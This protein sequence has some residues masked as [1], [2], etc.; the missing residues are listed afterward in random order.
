MIIDDNN[1]LLKVQVKFTS[2]K[3]KNNVFQVNLKS[4]GGTKGTVY[5]RV[6]E[7][8]IDILLAVTSEKDIYEIP[9]KD[10]ENKASLN[11]GKKYDKYKVFI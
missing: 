4:C 3:S 1:N 11:L 9:C 8:D 10:I 6:I 7:T 2:Y 5:K